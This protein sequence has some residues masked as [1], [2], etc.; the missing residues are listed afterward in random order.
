MTSGMRVYTPIAQG[1]VQAEDSEYTLTPLLMTSDAAYS[2]VDYQNA[3][4]VEK[5]DTDP[6]GSFAVAMAAQNDT[7]GA[8]VV[9]GNCPNM[10]LSTANQSVSGGN[11]Q[12][13]GSVVNW[14]NGEQTTAVINSKSM[15]AASLAVP[16]AARIGLALL[17]VFVLPIVCLIAGVVICLIRRRR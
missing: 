11:A 4:T 14:F 8:K 6:E 3:E 2:L 1:I 9:W 15:S 17:F 13:F 7:T 12:M 10:L 16:N 5:S